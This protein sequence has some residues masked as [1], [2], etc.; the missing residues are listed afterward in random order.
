MTEID[1]FNLIKKIFADNFQMNPDDIQIKMGMND[2]AQWGSLTH[3]FLID[4]IESEF[5]IE[6][7]PN[8]IEKSISINQIIIIIKN[9]IK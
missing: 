8:D 4:K 3:I 6:F 2:I 1:I 5:N 7:T 9:K